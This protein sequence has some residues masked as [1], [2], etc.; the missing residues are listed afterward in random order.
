MVFWV[1]N[2]FF[3]KQNK[4]IEDNKTENSLAFIE[5]SVFTDRYCFAKNCYESGKMNKI[6]YDIY[7]RWHDWL[8]KSFDVVPRAFIYLKVDPEISYER[9]K[10]EV[11]MEKI[12]Y[13]L[14]I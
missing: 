13:R 4:K 6:E 10:K 14:N 12:V 1:S 8:C 2:E 5:R 7:C 3:H 9:I 11:A